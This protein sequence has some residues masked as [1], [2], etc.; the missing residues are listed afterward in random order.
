[1]YIYMYTINASCAFE[2]QCR[3]LSRHVRRHI[4]VCI[5]QVVAR[6]PMGW[7]SAWGS[8]QKYGYIV[9]HQ[10]KWGGTKWATFKFLEGGKF[11]LVPP[12]PKKKPRILLP[13]MSCVVSSHVAIGSLGTRLLGT[14]LCTILT[15]WT[16]RGVCVSLW[17]CVSSG[18]ALEH[19]TAEHQRNN[20]VELQL[21]GRRRGW[22]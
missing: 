21:G 13:W 2:N 12:P 14:T 4:H 3:L 16:W 17:Q 11:P 22:E 5:G 20:P 1:M 10:T 15:I 19:H 9:I 7:Y 8:F 18:L 6:V